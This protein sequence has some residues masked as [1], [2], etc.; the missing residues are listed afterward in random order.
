MILDTGASE[1]LVLLMDDL[2]VK[3][4][5]NSNVISVYADETNNSLSTIQKDITDVEDKIE[6]M[7]SSITTVIKA[8]GESNEDLEAQTIVIDDNQWATISANM[9]AQTEFMRNMLICNVLILCMVAMIFGARIWDVIS[10]R[11][12]V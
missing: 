1:D 4:D 3:L 6:S 8:Q 7:E 5:D 12:A 10:K 2:S 11:W 9:T